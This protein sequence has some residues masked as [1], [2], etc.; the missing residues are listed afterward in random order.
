MGAIDRRLELPIHHRAQVAKYRKLERIEASPPP[1]IEGGDVLAIGR[2]LLVGLSS[3]RT[4]PVLG[5]S[6]VSCGN[7]AIKLCPFRWVNR[8]I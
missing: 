1:S 7:S 3:H 2:T 5:S 4:M 8:C 6:R